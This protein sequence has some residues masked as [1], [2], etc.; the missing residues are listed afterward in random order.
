MSALREW[1]SRVL[2]FV[3]RCDADVHDE[4]QFHLDMTEHRL[5]ESG[6]SAGEA[7][8]QARLTLG[9]A[10]PIAEAYRDQH[11]LPFPRRDPDV[12]AAFR[13]RGARRG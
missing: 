1:A 5:R 3:T 9:A 8:R 13:T 7:R 6:L 12:R 11:G 2:A 10:P 4:L